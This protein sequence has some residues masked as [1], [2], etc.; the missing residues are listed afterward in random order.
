A[1]LPL[2]RLRGM[3]EP[4]LAHAGAPVDRATRWRLLPVGLNAFLIGAGAGLVIPFMNLYFANRFG[5]SSGQ[6]GFYFS[7]AAVL[8]AVASLVGPAV[9]RRFGMLRT[10]V[11]AQVLSLPFLVTLGTET[12]L[13]VAVG[14]FWM[15]ATLMQA[16]TPLV[17]TFVMEAF[18]PSLRARSASLITLVWN[19]GW[20]VSATL[21][22]III[23]RFGYHVPFYITAV[24]YALAASTFYLSFRHM[25]VSE[26]AR[27]GPERMERPHGEGPLAD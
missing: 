9:A 5:C 12:R 21:S 22:G 24:L 10:A 26:A 27:R 7:M 3:A 2:L 19:A 4:V 1:C 16:S 23:Q 15:R 8:T 13:G 11:A 20:A 18:P 6:I 25:P 14:A 17:Q